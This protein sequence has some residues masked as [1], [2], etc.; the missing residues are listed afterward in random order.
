MST[1]IPTVLPTV[2]S[3]VQ[4]SVAT[5]PG[6]PVFY[7]F[8]GVD[9]FAVMDQ[10]W[11]ASSADFTVSFKVLTR[12]FGQDI[13]YL[14]SGSTAHR[15][16]QSSVAGNVTVAYRDAADSTRTA[17]EGGSVLDEEFEVIY[18]SDPTTGVT[19]TVAGASDDNPI[20]WDAANSP[21]LQFIG[22]FNLGG[23]FKMTGYI[24]DLVMTDPL[25]AANSRHYPMNEGDGNKFLCYDGNGTPVPANDATISN[26]DAANWRN[27]LP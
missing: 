12:V 11:E 9:G 19:L 17:S 18:A 5:P 24:R 13:G 7:Y 2:L 3:T 6:G 15:V 10:T 25:S 20:I 14:G 4:S 23:S 16:F 26:Y 1:V 27:D 22:A 8:N 21:D